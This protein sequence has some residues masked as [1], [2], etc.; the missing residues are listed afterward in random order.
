M[1]STFSKQPGVWLDINAHPQRHIHIHTQACAHTYTQYLDIHTQA[2]TLTEHTDTH[3]QVHARIHRK[4]RHTCTYRGIY[5]GA[6]IHIH[7]H[8]CIHTYTECPDIHA[9]AHTHAHTHR[10]IYTGIHTH[11]HM[12]YR[13]TH[14]IHPSSFT[15]SWKQLGYSSFRKALGSPDFYSMSF[16]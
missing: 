11:I 10:G 4:H 16:S 14:N 1:P 12:A 5:T 7:I 2:L 9:L 8:R 6:H 13:N 15:H 3:T